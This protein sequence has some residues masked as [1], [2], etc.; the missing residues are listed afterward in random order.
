LEDERGL[1]MRSIALLAFPAMLLLLTGVVAGR[2]PAD[3]E[4]E[5][6]VNVAGVAVDGGNW[7]LAAED[8]AASFEAYLQQPIQLVVDGRTASVAPAEIGIG[9]DVEATHE[10]VIQVGRGGL[11]GSAVERL[12][13]HTRGVDIAP[14]V[15]IDSQKLLE[16]LGAI[17]QSEITPPVDAAFVWDGAQLT[18]RPSSDG[19]GID[20]AA[21]A[22]TLRKAVVE[23]DHG[24]VE[25]A[26]V[27]LKPA[28]ATAD[29][30]RVRADAGALLAEPL[31]VTNGEQYWQITQPALAEMLSAKDGK[32]TLN[33]R[34]F[35]PLIGSLAVTIDRAAVSA[36]IVFNG[37]TTFRIEPDVTGRTLNVPAS[38]AAVERE[39]LAGEHLI[40][41]V[42]VET[43][44][45]LSEADLQPL[46]AR[47]NQIA[48]AG[49]AVS[50][51][52]GEQALDGTAFASAMLV[53]ETTGEITF[54][55]VAIFA[56]LEPIA[57][58]I[59]RPSSGY[60]WIDWSIV[61]P[62]GALPGRLVDIN[63]SVNRVIANALSGNT[64][65]TLVVSEQQ[66]ETAVAGEIVISDLLGTAS[67]YYGSSGNNRRINVE[68]A[69]SLL[70]GYLVAPG[71][72]FSFNK[73]IGGTATSDDGYQMG[74]GIIAGQNGVPQ[75]VP[76]VA[77]G[78]CQVA[79]TAFQAAFWSG[80]RIGERN[81][82]LY[83]IPNYGSGPG[84]MQGLDATVDPDYGLDNTWVNTTNNWVAINA[85]ADGEWI[86]I[87]IWGTN[88]GWTVSAENPIIE[89]VVK[90]N[91]TM[92]RQF[93]ADVP[94]GQ[95]VVVEHAQDGF[96]ATI[97]RTV[98]AAS[99][100]VIDDIWL[101]SYYLPSRN[102][103]LV[104]EGVSIEQP[105]PDPGE[106]EPVVEEPV[107]EE[108]VE[109]EPVV[110]PT[111]EPTAEPTVEPEPT[112]DE[113]SEPTE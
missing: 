63:A 102:V 78:I 64:T 73:A 2:P 111:P 98:A 94:A 110:E 91:S 27:P 13:A 39:L 36:E 75:T 76:S 66:D 113:I 32:L 46:L 41:L 14:V 88:Q 4:I 48:G 69:A 34:A 55:T 35:D 72:E 95:S 16:T 31:V 85:V 71:A 47:V 79:T 18:V 54:D 6:G 12:E 15:T 52:D 21:V 81:W 107:V 19:V 96:T 40:E 11:V 3:G 70:D 100:E 50:W 8:L 60:R 33:G 74:Y 9:F 38:V 62:D 51:P 20:A 58:S 90:A 17:G 97:H 106:E 5:R 1:L 105:A 10:R 83:W 101:A 53:D 103:T 22:E 44:P 109:E 84:G 65:T 7:N 86:T 37:D 61:A 112:E 29:L 99:G 82:H 42:I 93:S 68:L 80:V 108:P 30:E 26:I 56:M 104:G 67:T 23:L 28:V 92:V 59:N 77:G 45:A 49:V 43:A 25:I 57:H 87:E 24:P 89:N